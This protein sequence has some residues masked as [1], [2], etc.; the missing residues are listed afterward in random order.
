M[1][2]SKL[3]KNKNEKGH[4]FKEPFHIKGYEIVKISKNINNKDKTLSP[5]K[6]FLDVS[7]S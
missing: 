7:S 3:V 4:C 6:Y 1:L 2:M 5:D